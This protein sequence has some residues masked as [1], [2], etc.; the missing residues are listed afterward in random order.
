MG[1]GGQP[2]AG[3]D[4]ACHVLRRAGV[5]LLLSLAAAARRGW[6]KKPS[7]NSAAAGAPILDAFDD[8][9]V[10][11]CFEIHPG[12]D[13]H[14]GATFERFLDVVDH[15]PRAKILYDPSHLR[16]AA[17]RLPG[18]HRP[19]P[20]AHRVFHVKDAEF[21]PTR[22]VGRLWRLPGLDRSSGPVPLAGR[23]ADRLQAI[24]SQ[25]AQYDF[26]GWAVLEWECCLKHP[27]DGAREGAPF[28]RDHI[29]RVTEH[30]FDDFADSGDRHR[31]Q[32]PH[33][34]TV[35]GSANGFSYFRIT[36]IDEQRTLGAPGLD[37]ETWEIARRS[38]GAGKMGDKTMTVS[39]RD[40]IA[41]GT[42]G[43]LSTLA[44]G[45]STH[46]EETAQSTMPDTGIERRRLR[47][48]AGSGSP[49]MTCATT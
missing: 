2:A 4:R 15:H 42:V 16:A 25:L 35:D 26:P 23:W 20:R 14:D 24:F 11:L 34:G 38:M 29:I 32:S 17:D 10:D 33:S 21:R 9:G 48:A 13:L 1:R 3:T 43:A 8:A 47:C 7:P 40:L 12:E 37:S 6:W 30:A 19:L 46:A 39:R 45:A 28:I 49:H 27:E 22:A 44:P 41:L 36:L 31:T 5:A 18:L